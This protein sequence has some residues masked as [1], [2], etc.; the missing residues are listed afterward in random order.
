MFKK[1]H[2]MNIKLNIVK[3]TTDKNYVSLTYWF[4]N[5]NLTSIKVKVQD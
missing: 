5:N 3:I 2:G 1:F 4:D